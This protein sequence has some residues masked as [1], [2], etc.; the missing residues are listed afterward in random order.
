MGTTAGKNYLTDL[1]NYILTLCEKISACI[2]DEISDPE[3]KDQ[4][5]EEYG[6][7]A[8]TRDAGSGLGGGKLQRDALTTRGRT[9]K[10]P[11]SNRNFRWHPLVVSVNEIDFAKPIEKILINSND[12]TLIFVVEDEFGEQEMVDPSTTPNLSRRY[13]IL[14]EH[15]KPHYSVIK[16]W[17]KEWDNN[18]CVISAAE[19]C[20][21]YHAVEVYALL[22][23]SVACSFYGVSFETIYPKVVDIL[24]NQCVDNNIKLPTD[25]FPTDKDEFILDPISLIPLSEGLSKYRESERPPIWKPEWNAGKREE[26]EDSAIQIMHMKPLIE[27]EIRHRPSNVRY[28]FRWSNIA[29]TDHTKEETLNFFRDCVTANEESEKKDDEKK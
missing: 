24:K 25:E 23:I 9:G 4:F 18:L 3:L 17:D 26:G 21:W 14:D 12:N 1:D 13:T 22:G 8:R 16:K 28:G 7:I 11:I 19:A 15:W 20:E 6:K 10:M 5:M 27:T 29:M 2:K